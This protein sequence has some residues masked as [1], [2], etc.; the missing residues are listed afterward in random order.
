MRMYTRMDDWYRCNV[1]E[2]ENV[3]KNS[4]SFKWI[5]QK[6]HGIACTQCTH[7]NNTL[8]KAFHRFVYN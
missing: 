7:N 3:K 8:K 1:Y 2:Q 6:A 4:S 5:Q